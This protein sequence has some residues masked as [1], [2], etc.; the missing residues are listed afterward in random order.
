MNSFGNK[1]D[2]ANNNNNTSFNINN[3]ELEVNR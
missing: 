1:F 2:E 3:N